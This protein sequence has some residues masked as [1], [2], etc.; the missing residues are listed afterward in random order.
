MAE[1]KSVKTGSGGDRAARLLDCVRAV[2]AEL[3]PDRKADAV[4]LDSV[5]DRELGIDSLGR[6]EL[7]ARIEQA[8]GVTLPETAFAAAETPRDLLRALAGASGGAAAPGPRQLVVAAAPDQATLPLPRAAETLT[9]VLDHFATHYPNRVH[10]TFYSDDAD[11]ETLGYGALA[12]GAGRVAAGLRRA[13]L[14]PGEAV[15]IMLPTGVDY[16]LAFMG[17]LVAGGVP[18][19]LYPP[20]RPA[21]LEE[22]LRR[23]A[24]IVA[25]SGARFLIAVAEAERFAKML[26]SLV[27]SLQTVVTVADISEPAPDPAPPRR[28]PGDTAFL[29]YTSGSTGNPKGVVLSHANLLANIRAMGEALAVGPGDVMVSWLPL[30]HDMGLI[31]CWLGSLYHGVPLVI[32][33]P[34]A[35]LAR[36]ERWLDAIQRHRGTISGSPNFAYELCLRRVSEER[37]G[38]LDL[39][40]WRTAFNGAEAISPDTL[41]GFCDRF[42]AAGFARTAMMP[43]YGLAE[44]SVGLAFPP[45]GR[46]PVIDRVER[47][48]FTG[49]GR[50]L[51][52]AEDDARALRF[53]NCGRPLPG[54]QIRIVD[55]GDQE[56]PERR[57]GRLQFR[58]PSATSGYLGDAE[59]TARLFAGD[60]LE[61]GD[62]GYMSGGDVYIT[63]RSKDVIIRGGRNIYPTEIE[64]AI[65]GLDG[66]RKGGVAVF[67]SPDPK[68]AT[69]RLIVLAETRKRQDDAR[70]ALRGEIT[71]LVTDLSGVPPDDVVLAGPRTVPKTSSGKIRRAASREFYERGRIDAPALSLRWQV[72]R[73]ALSAVRPAAQRLRA[74]VLDRLYGAYALGLTAL[75]AGP[76]WLGVVAAPAMAWRWA[77]ARRLIRG[78]FWAAGIRVTVRGLENLPADNR[79]FVVVGN[80]MSNLDGFLLAAFLPG[81]WR[82]VAKSELRANRFSRAG[83]ERIGVVFVERFDLRQSVN[84]A[85]RIA[86]TVS[87]GAPLVFFAEGTFTRAVGLR[88]FQMGAFAAA[89]AAGAAV[90]PVAIRG[91]RAILRD[92]TMLIRRGAVTVTVG[93]PVMPDPAAGADPQAA[94]LDAIRLRDEAR[95]QILRHCGEPDL[96][97]ER[98]EIFDA[99]GGRT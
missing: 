49:S 22:H 65:G 87:A 56:L 82:F 67:A 54:H 35:F 90:V 86:K 52:A 40:S 6:V 51:A 59:A 16:F 60:W 9:E 33:S 5:L 10:V 41:D 89:Q 80:H 99:G 11:G 3:Q 48:A 91:T 8:F 21:Q 72:L 28:R 57:E 69:E 68:S 75:V 81:R 45:L 19:P 71:A 95:S 93:A 76:L 92:G 34:L 47:D 77:V 20:G 46:G 64:D 85:G 79:G 4:G 97:H 58:G 24:A 55:T 32:M 12:K 66:I 61:S 42:A 88:A 27:A 25:N 23:H 39:S 70:D 14:A 94:W 84:D 63:G 7:F 2:F 26:K 29:Q 98:P 18:A 50:A 36:P 30:Y 17:V 44:S 74:F 73:V 38:E 53:V 1:N 83:L 13:G 78:L 37:L 43:V 15:A 31:G 96:A 62:L